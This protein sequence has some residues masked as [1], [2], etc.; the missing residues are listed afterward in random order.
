M[1]GFC[2][3]VR[4]RARF[5][6][7]ILIVIVFYGALYFRWPI[8]RH[9]EVQ[10]QPDDQTLLLIPPNLVH[11]AFVSELQAFYVYFSMCPVS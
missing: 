10:G 4:D 11:M 3:R 2:R 8:C 9:A 1:E 7:L 6:R 5:A